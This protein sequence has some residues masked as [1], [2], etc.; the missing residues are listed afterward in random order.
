MCGQTEGKVTKGLQCRT[1]NEGLGKPIRQNSTESEV[2]P[3]KQ[4]GWRELSTRVRPNETETCEKRARKVR[5]ER[6]RARKSPIETRVRV[7]RRDRPSEYKRPFESTGR[8]GGPCE[9]AKHR[10]GR[11][12]SRGGGGQT[13]YDPSTRVRV[14]E[15]ARTLEAAESDRT[16]EHGDRD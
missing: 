16:L 9:V 13:S 15:Q 4:T 11:A 2:R 10:R 12:A 6:V 3:A 7:D 8:I 14:A 1:R 5:R